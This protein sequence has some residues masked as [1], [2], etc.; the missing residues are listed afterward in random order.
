MAGVEFEFDIT[1]RSLH[2]GDRCVLDMQIKFHE[3]L[4]VNVPFVEA[5]GVFR[6]LGLDEALLPPI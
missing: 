6:C 2:E 1:A 4:R 3:I 5:L